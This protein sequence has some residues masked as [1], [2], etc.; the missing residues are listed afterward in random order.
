MAP[1]RVSRVEGLTSDI[2]TVVETMKMGLTA[3][4]NLHAEQI[5][6]HIHNITLCTLPF[7][8]KD[9]QF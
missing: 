2:S 4:V 1:V 5:A 9:L 3:I 6:Q 8:S 7:T